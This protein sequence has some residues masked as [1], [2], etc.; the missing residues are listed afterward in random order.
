M[1]EEI[2]LYEC[3]KGPYFIQFSQNLR[4][5]CLLI[6]VFSQEFTWAEPK[7]VLFNVQNN[8]RFISGK[9]GGKYRNRKTITF[10]VMAELNKIWNSLI[11]IERTLQNSFSVSWFHWWYQKPVWLALLMTEVH[12]IVCLRLLRIRICIRLIFLWY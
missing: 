8:F 6:F 12:S 2:Q 7:I 5:D 11:F 1:N 4:C 10:K 3:E 9:F